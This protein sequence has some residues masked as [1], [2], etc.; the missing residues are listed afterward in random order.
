MHNKIK[1]ELYATDCEC[2]EIK[3]YTADRSPCFGCQ[4][5][6]KWPFKLGRMYQTAHQNDGFNALRLCCSKLNP[7]CLWYD[8]K[9]A[10]LHDHKARWANHSTSQSSSR[11]AK[12]GK[13]TSLSRVNKRSDIHLEVLSSQNRKSFEYFLCFH[14]RRPKRCLW[15]TYVTALRYVLSHLRGCMKMVRKSL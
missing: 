3:F 15:F 14:H 4:M 6:K 7:A 10:K 5:F 8:S 11:T 2:F 12:S 1:R 13:F 9:P